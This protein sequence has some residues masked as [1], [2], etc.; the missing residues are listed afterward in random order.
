MPTSCTIE[1]AR[2]AIVKVNDTDFQQRVAI[3]RARRP[4][5]SFNR[6]LFSTGDQIINFT[7]MYI[8]NGGFHSI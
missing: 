6:V 5:I 4:E 7:D 2:P 1:Q 3:K 8:K